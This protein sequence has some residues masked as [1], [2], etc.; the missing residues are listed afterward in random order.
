MN[1]SH[2]KIIESPFCIY[3]KHFLVI[4][5]ASIKDLVPTLPVRLNLSLFARLFFLHLFQ[6][7]I[8]LFERLTAM[9]KF[10]M[11]LLFLMFTGTKKALRS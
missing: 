3:T 11:Q 7:F 10:Q 4:R 1:D 2:L 8:C 5:A 9:E 6:S